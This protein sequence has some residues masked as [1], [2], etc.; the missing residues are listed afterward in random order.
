MKI[1]ITCPHCIK[2]IEATGDVIGSVLVCP[3]CHKQL[4]VGSQYN[5]NPTCLA[6]EANKPGTAPSQRQLQQIDDVIV[7]SNEIKTR[8]ASYPIDR[9]T[10]VFV[11]ESELEVFALASGLMLVIVDFWLF[12]DT[13]VWFWAF[14]AFGGLSFVFGSIGHYKVNIGISSGQ[15]TI[16][17]YYY[18]LFLGN[19]EANGK[20]CALKNVV[21]ETIKTGI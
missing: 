1:K 19:T 8:N 13:G 6:P 21:V 3:K 20:A 5:S 15:H 9:Q 4:R 16:K 11:I 17:E 7:T 14:L 12:K 10:A 18:C 2:E